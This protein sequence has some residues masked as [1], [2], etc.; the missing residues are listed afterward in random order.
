M[1]SPRTL[2]RLRD[3]LP[4]RPL[5]QAEALLLAEL[6]AT[7]LLALTDTTT[8]PVPS[9]VVSELAG[10]EVRFVRSGEAPVSGLFRWH[11]GRYLIVLD[12]SERPAGR[13][14]FSLAH[15]FKHAVDWPF[16]ATLYPALPGMTS[17][18][19]Q[20]QV[21]DHFAACL[22]MPRS[23]VK[24]AWCQGVQEV[25]RLSRRFGVSPT[26]M[27]VRLHVLGLTERTRRCSTAA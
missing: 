14:R 6:Q 17:R 23:W 20:E 15:E 10:I 7:R 21:C 26:A 13:V 22:L 24:R 9:E 3:L 4:L 8:G 5:T 18:E 25:S 12:G 1:S 16:A 27:R 2:S 19:R 11:R